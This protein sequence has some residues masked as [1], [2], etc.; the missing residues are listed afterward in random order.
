MPDTLA[1]VIRELAGRLGEM[2][3][4]IGDRAQQSHAPPP[5]GQPDQ[6]ELTRRAR[7]LLADR[8]ERLDHFPS[9]LFH[10]PAWEMLVGLFLERDAPRPLT[11]KTLSTY[12][13]APVTISQRWIEHLFRMGLVT[14]TIDPFDRRRVEVAL[15]DLG[16]ERMTRYLSALPAAIPRE[17]SRE[18]SPQ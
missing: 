10:E 13:H 11:V 7:Q 18:T 12:A 6:A 17:L 14:R 1:D 5:T 9:E 2:A 8:A 16:L 3:Q 4:E 15:S